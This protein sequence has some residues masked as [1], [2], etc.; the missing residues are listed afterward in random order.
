[1]HRSA[2]NYAK[3]VVYNLCTNV[4]YH[5]LI[6]TI[7]FIESFSIDVTE[8]GERTSP[9]LQLDQNVQVIPPGTEYTRT[10]TNENVNEQENE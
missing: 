6:S 10:H 3:A 2:E 1:M 4:D 8:F 5:H 9:E 7:E